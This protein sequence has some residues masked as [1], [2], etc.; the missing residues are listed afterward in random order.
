M[1]H[2]LRDLRPAQIITM[3]GGSR[4]SIPQ[5]NNHRDG[6]LKDVEMIML[7]DVEIMLRDCWTQG[8]AGDHKNE[9]FLNNCKENIKN[10]TI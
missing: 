10:K 8:A 3:E 4:S 7:K 1:L 2:I 9:R 5:G 6:L